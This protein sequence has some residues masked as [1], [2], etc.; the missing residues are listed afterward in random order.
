MDYEGEPIFKDGFYIYP[1]G[2]TVSEGDMIEGAQY[3]DSV[4]FDQFEEN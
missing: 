2:S 1:D 4:E 3:L